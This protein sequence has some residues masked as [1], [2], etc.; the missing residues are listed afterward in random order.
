MQ[1]RVE[2]CAH[3]HISAS[4]ERATCCGDLC[5]CTLAIT[6]RSLLRKW[7]PCVTPTLRKAIYL[8]TRPGAS[9]YLTCLPL[10]EH[11]FNLHNCDFV[12]AWLC[13]M[14]GP[15]QGLHQLMYAGPGLL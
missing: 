6:G 3:A 9:S 7:Q 13:A 1:R 14:A 15:F 5:A 8:A 4:K 12:D 11:S 10:K 2:I